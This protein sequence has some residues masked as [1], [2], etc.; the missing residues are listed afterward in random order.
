LIGA[1][2][3]AVVGGVAG[4]AYNEYEVFFIRKNKIIKFL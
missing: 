3:G 1:L 4:V 2:G